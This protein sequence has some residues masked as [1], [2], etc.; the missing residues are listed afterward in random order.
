MLLDR[1]VKLEE[2]LQERA[3]LS[4][5]DI[6][7]LRGQL[8]GS[9]L[10]QGCEAALRLRR[11]QFP[12]SDEL[13]RQIPGVEDHPDTAKR[14]A[15]A[16]LHTAEACR[17]FDDLV[18]EGFAHAARTVKIRRGVI[19]MALLCAAFWDTVRMEAEYGWPFDAA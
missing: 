8:R 5:A 3:G 4:H 2:V 13:E 16:M 17:I 19:I 11:F 15:R 7:T 10:L 14:K 18:R 12:T 9:R 1:E 6:V